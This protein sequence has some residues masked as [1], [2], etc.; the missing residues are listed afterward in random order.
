[1]PP[2]EWERGREG[3]GGNGRWRVTMYSDCG[4]KTRLCHRV[5]RIRGRKGWGGGGG[6]GEG[7]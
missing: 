7:G 6:G 2:S 1:M 4:I 5:T 3:G